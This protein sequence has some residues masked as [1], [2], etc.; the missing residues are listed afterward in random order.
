M[1]LHGLSPDIQL[2]GNHIKLMK[3]LQGKIDIDTLNGWFHLPLV[4]KKSRYIFSVHCLF[5]NFISKGDKENFT[6][7]GSRPK[8]VTVYRIWLKA[9]IGSFSTT[10]SASSGVKHIPA[11]SASTISAAS[12]AT[13]ISIGTPMPMA[14]K[15]F[16]G[17][18][19]SKSAVRRGWRNPNPTP[20]AS[21]RDAESPAKP[22]QSQ[23]SHKYR[24]LLAPFFK[25]KRLDDDPQYI[26]QRCL[27]RCI[28]RAIYMFMMR[29]SYDISPMSGIVPATN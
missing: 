11:F 29:K 18:T 6:E 1:S 20:Q 9:E 13:P 3:H 14:S 21:P 8:S 4:R 10:I 17:I 7:Y 24:S 23:A 27:A 19:V 5:R 22:L 15:I 2:F 25:I 26:G 12:P 28:D 16:E